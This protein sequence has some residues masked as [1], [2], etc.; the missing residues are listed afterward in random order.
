MTGTAGEKK[1]HFFSLGTALSHVH[2]NTHTERERERERERWRGREREKNALSQRGGDR[3]LGEFLL[4]H[5]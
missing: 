2:I 3:A 4:K 5:M 1:G